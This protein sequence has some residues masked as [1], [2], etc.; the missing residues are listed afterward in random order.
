MTIGILFFSHH[1]FKI[2]TAYA[3]LYFPFMVIYLVNTLTGVSQ[4]SAALKN[5]EIIFLLTKK[6]SVK[7]QTK[8][9]LPCPAFRI[10][11]KTRK[12]KYSN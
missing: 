11:N 9:V 5:K 12:S 4:K 10:N 6:F 7:S 8:L 1:S 3:S 2:S